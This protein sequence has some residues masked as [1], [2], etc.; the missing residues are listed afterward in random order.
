MWFCQADIGVISEAIP[1]LEKA[2]DF[3]HV[4]CIIRHL[5]MLFTDF[6]LAKN[7]IMCS[8]SEEGCFYQAGAFVQTASGVHL[9]LSQ[10]QAQQTSVFC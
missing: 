3:F 4:F 2:I 8:H 7:K 9:G 6:S 10:K 1:A 5:G